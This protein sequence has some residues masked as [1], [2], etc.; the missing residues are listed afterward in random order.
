[1][2][3]YRN[4]D[5]AVNKFSEGSVYRFE[6]ETVE[7]TLQDYLQDNPDKT[8]ADFK[9]LKAISDQIYYDQDRAENAQTKKNISLHGLEE[10][11]VCASDDF[12]EEYVLSED[13]RRAMQAAIRLFH[14]GKMTEKQKRR[15]LLH[16]MHG[17]PLRKIAD[18]EGVHFTSVDE[19]IR[20]AG[21]KLQAYFK[22][23]K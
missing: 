3:N 17:M 7:I 1:M 20:R 13:K 8:E 5:Y 18:M 12:E 14:D 22:Q 4:S 9:K 16:F 6:N 10:T 11:S 19:S 23:I 21:D 2:K 15:F